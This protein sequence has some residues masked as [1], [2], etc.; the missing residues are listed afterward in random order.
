MCDGVYSSRSFE[1][2]TLLVY[3]AH[4]I[5]L[6][7]IS[8]PATKTRQGKLNRKQFVIITIVDYSHPLATA[9]HQACK[10]LSFFA[11]SSWASAET[12]G[13]CIAL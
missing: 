4:G 7:R 3:R 1:C 11:A 13:L 12:F 9:R 5:T 6:E 2:L 10:L 8:G